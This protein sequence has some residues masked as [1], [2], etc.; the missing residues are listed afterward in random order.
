MKTKFLLP[1]LACMAM[2]FVAC[3]DKNQPQEPQKEQMNVSQV[4]GVWGLSLED[5]DT[6]SFLWYYDFAQDGTAQEFVCIDGDTRYYGCYLGS[7]D[8]KDSVITF[9]ED[10]YTLFF[11]WNDLP[12]IGYFNNNKL[13]AE[14][15]VIRVEKDKITIILNNDTTCYLFKLSQK[16]EGMA[17]EFFEKEKAVS[18]ETLIGPWDQQNYFTISKNNDFRWWAYDFPELNGMH[19]LTDG[20]FQDLNWTEWIYDW[21]LA[22]L[23][24]PESWEYIWRTSKISWDLYQNT[25]L[26]FYCST[27]DIAET[28]AEGNTIN[29]TRQ[30]IT[31]SDPKLATYK[32]YSLTDHYMILY[33]TKKK[34][35]Y[36]F[37]P[38]QVTPDAAP[39]RLAPAMPHIS[40][41]LH[42]G[43]LTLVKFG[44]KELTDANICIY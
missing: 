39:Q 3:N 25:H 40:S 37:T 27:F 23:E 38:G 21:C 16:P 29:E 13:V 14:L 11:Y 20:K 43:S 28:D 32:V 44:F 2:S 18:P 35:Y 6:P 10:K 34:E 22:N 42:S 17:P 26:N 1:L 9:Y 31:P 41:G 12:R 4:V 5:N 30:T 24:L 15:K 19:L 7:Y 36:V 33:S 8:F